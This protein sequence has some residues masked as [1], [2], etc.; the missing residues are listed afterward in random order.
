MSILTAVAFLTTRVTK[1]AEDDDGKL[2]EVLKYLRGTPDIGLVLKSR[3]LI[4]L[5]AF[6]DV[7]HAVPN[8][9]KVRGGA[10]ARIDNACVYASSTSQ[11]VLLRSSF[12]AK[13]HA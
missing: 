8:G 6:V 7:L 5:G 2:L 1:T 11:K 4:A 12:E 3:E 10:I 9:A 13:L